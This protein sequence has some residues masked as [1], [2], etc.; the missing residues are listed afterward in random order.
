MEQQLLDDLTSYFQK[1]TELSKEERRLLNRLTNGDFPI[2]SVHREDLAHKGF[3]IRNISN[4]DME[5]LARK[6]SND[7]QDQ[8]FWES[9]VIIAEELNFPRHPPCPYCQSDMVYL[10]IPH[11]VYECGNCGQEWHEGAYVLVTFPDAPS[12]FREKHIGYPSSEC[13]N[14]EAQYVSVDEYISHFKKEPD[15]NKY[16]RPIRWPDS[17]KYMPKNE[18]GSIAALCETINDEY[19]IEDF[20]ANALWVPLCSIH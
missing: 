18:N 11:C 20:G 2:T 4:Q 16:Y 6:M 1:K 5:E 9:M 3:D 19:G 15:G 10:S 17:R 7:Y 14:G 12:F 13:S 8:L